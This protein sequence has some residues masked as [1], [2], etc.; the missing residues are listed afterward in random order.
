MKT[1]LPLVNLEEL[2]A[3]VGGVDPMSVL[4]RAREMGG[5]DAL[6]SGATAMFIDGDIA[7]QMAEEY[8]AAQEQQREDEADYAAY[9]AE[10]QAR[11][12]VKVQEAYDVA[13]KQAYRASCLLLTALRSFSRGPNA[14]LLREL[15]G[16][17]REH[18]A[19]S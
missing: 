13:R 12:R 11:R 16:R 5:I 17:R 10:R 3:R 7:R 1:K 2:A 6:V 8:D 4:A 9:K 18:M 19:S 15:L 14:G